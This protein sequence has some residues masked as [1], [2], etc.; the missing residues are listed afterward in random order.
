MSVGESGTYRL[1][2]VR[3]MKPLGFTSEGMRDVL[4]IGNVA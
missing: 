2:L 1:H 3:H 4:E